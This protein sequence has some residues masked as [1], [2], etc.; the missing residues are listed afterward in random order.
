MFDTDI[1]HIAYSFIHGGFDPDSE[2]GGCSCTDCSKLRKR[3][4][5]IRE[6]E[7][8]EYMENKYGKGLTR[9]QC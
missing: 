9:K 3:I 5:L 6:N 7:G 2:T 8:K 1:D 4:K